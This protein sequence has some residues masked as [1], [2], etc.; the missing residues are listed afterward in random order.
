MWRGEVWRERC[1]RGESASLS[2]F[3]MCVT[4]GILLHIIIYYIVIAFSMCVTYGI[5]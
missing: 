5:L 4:Y 1:G 3:S 2:A